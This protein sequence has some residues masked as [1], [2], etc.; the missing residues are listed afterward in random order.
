MATT[1]KA[2][3]MFS[4]LSSC[5]VEDKRLD[6][7]AAPADDSGGNLGSCP[8]VATTPGM[9]VYGFTE[10]PLG[11]DGIPNVHVYDPNDACSFADGDETG[12]WTWNVPSV[13]Y[14]HFRSDALDLLP[15]AAWIDPLEGASVVAPYRYRHGSA[16]DLEALSTAVGVSPDVATTGVLFVDAL[17][18]SMSC[19]GGATVTISAAHSGSFREYEEGLFESSNLTNEDRKDLFFTNVAPGPLTLTAVDPAGRDCVVP[20]DVVVAAAEMT[21]VSVYCYR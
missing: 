8:D 10:D 5:T 20:D 17:D 12:Q 11:E 14:L 6:S 19:I 7:A 4:I 18:L 16:A 1:F 15:V 21:Q 2:L 9:T 3:L 13:D